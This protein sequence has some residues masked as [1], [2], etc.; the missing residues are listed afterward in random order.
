MKTLSAIR[1]TT[2]Q[3]PNQEKVS[4]SPERSTLACAGPAETGGPRRATREGV[5]DNS[6]LC[7]LCCRFIAGPRETQAYDPMQAGA[8]IPLWR[9][10]EE[11]AASFDPPVREQ[12]LRPI[13]KHCVDQSACCDHPIRA[14]R[15]HFTA[16][17]AVGR[18]FLPAS[19][20]GAI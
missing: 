15:S 9:Q 19:V 11:A 12:L 10:K 7:L 2:N 8:C 4:L 20:I 1:A 17:P 14:R 13:S 6:A 5:A 16:S 3:K 18:E